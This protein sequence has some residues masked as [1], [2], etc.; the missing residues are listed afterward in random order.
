MAL[1]TLARL[2]FDEPEAAADELERL[3]AWPPAAAGGGARLLADIAASAAPQLAARSLAALA[4]AHPDPDGFTARLRGRLGFR[5]R[6]VP[7]VA[8]SRSLGAW[9]ATHP[10]EADRLADGRGFAAPR[11]RDELVAEAVATVSARHGADPA[12]AWDALRRFKRRELLRVAVRDLAGQ[13]VVD[14]VAA[15]LADLADACLEAALVVATGESGYD[16]PPMRLAVLGMGKLGGSELN[17]V[18]DIDVMFCHEP[19]SGA[20]PEAAARAAERGGQGGHAGAVGRHPRGDL[21][22]GRRQPPARGPQRAAV[23]DP[24]QLPGLLGP[25]G[26]AVGAAG[27]DQ[28]PPGGGRRRPGRAVPRPRPPSGSTP[29]GSTPRRS[30]RCGA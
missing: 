3:G 8:A 6:L 2:G 20:E 5:R 14:E 27:P 12:A 17:Y 15:E 25:L 29:S 19:V 16:P 7:L 10:E 26:P 30:R 4:A 23:A 13:V 24:G 11:P 18:S 9:L 22:R 1:S 21:L 28:G